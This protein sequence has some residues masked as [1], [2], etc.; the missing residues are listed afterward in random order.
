MES[1]K[2]SRPSR[3]RGFTTIIVQLQRAH[4]AH[5]LTATCA[6]V[7]LEQLP[8]EAPGKEKTGATWPVG[9]P[10]SDMESASGLHALILR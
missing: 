2:P 1:A 10:H 9:M 6:V 7:A 5:A 3:P 4:D 8:F